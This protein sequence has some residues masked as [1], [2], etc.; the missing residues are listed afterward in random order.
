MFAVQYPVLT[1]PLRV[2]QT[3]LA[4]TL[5]PLLPP[6]GIGMDMPKVSR[7]AL[8]P[9]MDVATLPFFLALRLGADF[10]GRPVFTRREGLQANL[11]RLLNR[12][13]SRLKRLFLLKRL[14]LLFFHNLFNYK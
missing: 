13:R 4:G 8:I 9:G 10:L 2:R 1:D 6:V 11:A 5:T 3:P 7:I 12:L 14:L